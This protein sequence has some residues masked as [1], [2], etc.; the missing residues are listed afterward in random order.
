MG[1]IEKGLPP[2]A[3]ALRVNGS[4]VELWLY[5]AVMQGMEF[6]LPLNKE[7]TPAR[8]HAVEVARTWTRALLPGRFGEGWLPDVDGPRIGEAFRVLALRAR[9]PQPGDLLAALP[10][11]VESAE[12][13]AERAEMAARMKAQGEEK[14]ARDQ[15]LRAEAGE[16]QRR[17]LVALTETPAEAAKAAKLKALREKL[18]QCRAA[19][20]IPTPEEQADA[21]ELAQANRIRDSLG[22]PRHA[23]LAALRRH[24]AAR[25]NTGRALATERATQAR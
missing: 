8:D 1:S 6:L 16:Q 5:D 17:Q 3:P 2:E 4:G 7:N 12:Q 18:D 22:M 24:R 15:E 23:D 9:F 11:R 21:R 20:G 10:P 25:Q 19:A 14:A 13:Q